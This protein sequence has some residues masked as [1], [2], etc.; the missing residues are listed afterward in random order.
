MDCNSCT[1]YVSNLTYC[2]DSA[3]TEKNDK[4]GQFEVQLMNLPF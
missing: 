4:F 3:F 2:S 1:R